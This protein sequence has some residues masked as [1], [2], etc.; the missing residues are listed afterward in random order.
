MPIDELNPTTENFVPTPNNIPLSGSAPIPYRGNSV[1]DKSQEYPSFLPPISKGATNL[2]PTV[3]SGELYNARRF[4]I[5]D[6]TKTENEYA[7]GQSIGDKI[8]NGVGKGISLTGTTF[9]QSTAG[10]LNGV[11]NWIT[12]GKFSS[13]YNNDFN[14]ALDKWNDELENKLPNY[15]TDAEKNARWYSPS[16]WF[17]ANFLWDGIIKNLGFSAGAWLSGEVYAAG[18]KALSSLPGIARLASIGK[19]AETVAATEEGMLAV[20]KVASTYGKIKSLSNKYLSAYNVLNMGQRITVAGLA[21]TGEAGFEAFNNAN[22]YRDNI[23]A[24]YKKSH[25]GEEPTGADLEEINKEANKVGNYSFLMNVALLS[26]TNYIQFPKILG[27]SYKAERGISNSITH[28]IGRIVEK[29]GKYIAEPLIKSKFLSTINKI[30]PYLFSTSEGFEEGAQYM[31]TVG[32]QN[33]YD[34]GQNDL[35]STKFVD[36]LMENI[37]IGGL[38]GTMMMARGNYREQKEKSTNT[39]D[40]VK[41]FNE[42][43][44]SEFTKDVL[45]SVTRGI[46]LQE[47]RE[48]SIKDGRVADSKDLE[49]DYI[50][51]Y[52]SPRIK[53]GRWD[54]VKADLDDYRRLAS[55]DEGFAQLQEEG[56]ALKTDTKESY[57]NRLNSL[58]A[59]AD[60]VKSLYQSLN[61]RYGSLIDKKGAR[62]YTPEVIDKM[63]YSTTKVADYDKR[64]MSLTPKLIG[65]GVNID[66]VIKEIIDGKSEAF[67]DAVEKIKTLDVID[68]KKTELG[69]AINDVAELSLR[70]NEFLK[71]YSELKSSP[72]EHQETKSSPTIV[73]SEESKPEGQRE[74][75]TIKT[76]AGERDVEIG[77]EYFLGNVVEYDEKGHEVIRAPKLK[78]LG[79]NED[80]T[81]KI[82]DNNGKVRDVSP[83][84]LEDYKL[85]KV[86]TTLSNKK[87]KFFM[88]HWNTVYE[89][90]FGKGNKQI[91]RLRYSDKEGKLLFVYK[92]KKGKIKEI[93]VTGDQFVAKKGFREPMI[94]A[95]GELSLVQQKALSEFS[96]E[97]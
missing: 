22:Q 87:A 14:K 19:I 8:V 20:D 45:S 91:G 94:K 86:S 9:L 10:M 18:L 84:V 81:I 58:E 42:H 32:T 11:A 12:D 16:K 85:A 90:N 66:T 2:P 53:Y 54:L 23:I 88:E 39:Q 47:E 1:T 82:Q 49:M 76:K 67:N 56:K 15:Y 50:I 62:L 60:N 97:R 78:I 28:E 52:L 35:S 31:I 36:D 46:V 63:V 33:Y 30:R 29:E 89:F 34:K 79:K 77:T 69:E 75:I 27:S 92:N 80:G 55:T 72:K 4:D 57:L 6:P 21:T 93:E 74:K 41:R 61:L 70:R 38:S 73:T 65:A 59:T 5:Y 13:F 71:E 25:N 48:Q 26:A 68:E 24:E 7:Y 3:T 17:T 83:S 51:N 96:S 95:V 64:I 37:M 43:N 40:A 44:F